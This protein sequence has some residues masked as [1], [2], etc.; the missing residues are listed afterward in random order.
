MAAA[1]PAPSPYRAAQSRGTCRRRD[2]GGRWNPCR[3]RLCAG[4]G[5]PARGCPIG[6][7]REPGAADGPA[8]GR[9]RGAQCSR[10]C[11][12][13]R[14]EGW[15]CP[16]LESLGFHVRSANAI[17]LN[18]RPAVEM[19]LSDGQHYATVVEQHPADAQQQSGQ[20]AE[21]NSEQNSGEN[22][23]KLLVSS[24][25][26]WTA[27]VETTAGTSLLSPTSRRSRPM[28]PFLCCSGSASSPQQESTRVSHRRL[29][30]AAGTAA[31]DSPAAR[32][33]RGIHKIGGC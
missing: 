6:H 8:T 10:S 29:L 9:R 19:H 23:G 22:E 1:E 15:V 25:A 33:E 30:T 4:G 3:R 32:L 20:D 31:D 26:P 12:G 14:S 7:Q 21:Q 2:S 27:T 5:Q 11:L 17:T 13:L 24:L 18:G 16:D 28:T